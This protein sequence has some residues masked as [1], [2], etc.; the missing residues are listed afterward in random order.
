MDAKLLQSI[1][2]LTL[3]VIELGK[4][5]QELEVSKKSGFTEQK[6]LTTSE[7]GILACRCPVWKRL[8]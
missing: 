2:E 1:E 5:V 7:C 3:H 6:A 4:R 8:A